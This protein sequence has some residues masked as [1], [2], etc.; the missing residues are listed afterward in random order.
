MG[1]IA[2]IIQYEFLIV[3][4]HN[5]KMSQPNYDSD[6]S[7]DQNYITIHVIAAA[8]STQK[9]CKILDV[10]NT[11]KDVET[12]EHVTLCWPLY[13]SANTKEGFHNLSK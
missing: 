10:H 7:Y 8:F 3:K 1:A 13:S 6:N 9:P 11:M 2:N 4:I 5:P 12:Q